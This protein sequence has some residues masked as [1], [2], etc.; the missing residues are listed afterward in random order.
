[1]RL[2]FQ[3]II[4][5]KH[6]S[7]VPF[8]ARVNRYASETQLRI[9][10]QQVKYSELGAWMCGIW[11]CSSHLLEWYTSRSSFHLVPL[12][13]YPDRT[14]SLVF[15]LL[16]LCA[17]SKLQSNTKCSENTFHSCFTRFLFPNLFNTAFAAVLGLF[18]SRFEVAKTHPFDFVNVAS[19]LYSLLAERGEAM[20]SV[21]I[22]KEPTNEWWMQSLPVIYI[23]YW[24]RINLQLLFSHLVQ[25]NRNIWHSNSFTKDSWHELNNFTQTQLHETP[26]VLNIIGCTKKIQSKI[27][28]DYSFREMEETPF[29][30]G[31]VGHSQCFPGFCQAH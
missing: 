30:S 25:E 31:M 19:G 13:N 7:V 18:S 5:T 2:F 10:D 3:G 21:K 11:F 14:C 20:V 4:I 15:N 17:L 23:F 22:K 12:A 8:E 28:S 16:C 27:L 9:F 6:H 24:T 1:M 26:V 29:L